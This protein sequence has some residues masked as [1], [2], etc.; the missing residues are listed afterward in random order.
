MSMNTP[1]SKEKVGCSSVCSVSE[2]CNDGVAMC[3]Y[4]V[5][6]S[7]N[8]PFALEV[9]FPFFAAKAKAAKNHSA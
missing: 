8:F 1:K 4:V 2:V 6:L 9:V 5:H 3:T 7:S